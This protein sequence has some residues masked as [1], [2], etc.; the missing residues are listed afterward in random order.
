MPGSAL[1][2]QS[3]NGSEIG[4]FHNR[5]D[6]LMSESFIEYFAKKLLMDLFEER[7]RDVARNPK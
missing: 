3:P 7:E 5:E 4:D 2:V 1:V 6:E